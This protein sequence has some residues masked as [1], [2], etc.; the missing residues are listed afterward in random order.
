MTWLFLF[1]V[2]V[3]AFVVTWKRI[4]DLG[5][6]SPSTRALRAVAMRLVYYPLVQ[7]VC[8]T[9]IW[10]T[11]I[12]STGSDQ[13]DP[14]DFFPLLVDSL[15]SPLLGLGMF[16]AFLCHQ[17]LARMELWRCF[18]KP[19][20]GMMVF[21]TSFHYMSKTIFVSAGDNRR[22]LLGSEAPMSLSLSSMER[23]SSDEVH[24]IRVSYIV[25]PSRDSFS[26][27]P[28]SSDHDSFSTENPLASSSNPS[29]LSRPDGLPFT[30]QQRMQSI[31]SV[32]SNT[33]PICPV[34]PPPPPPAPSISHEVDYTEVEDDA[35]IAIVQRQLSTDIPT[36]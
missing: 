15:T 26:T 13:A 16:I 34:P 10:V 29:L 32:S 5:V 36:P 9:F 33:F 12:T 11:L 22:S 3:V 14:D 19:P 23:S 18:N 2:C 30:T 17:P 21:N 27:R 8:W 31:Q 6:D 25:Q 7:V 35:L 4:N 1:L 20:K 28:S 24:E